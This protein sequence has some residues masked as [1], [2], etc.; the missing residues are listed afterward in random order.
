MKLA[1]KFGRRMAILVMLLV[2]ASIITVILV[3]AYWLKTLGR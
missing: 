2:V 3:I 1:D